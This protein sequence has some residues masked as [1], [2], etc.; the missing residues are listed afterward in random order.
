MKNQEPSQ[1]RAQLY[2]LKVTLNGITPPIWRTLVCPVDASLE[3]LSVLIQEAFGWDG[4]HLYKFKIGKTD[5]D[6]DPEMFEEKNSQINTEVP[7]LAEVTLISL[8]LKKGD[9]FEY[10][11]DFGDDWRHTIAVE[12]QRD[13]RVLEPEFGCRAGERAAPFEDCGGIVGYQE[14]LAAKQDKKHPKRQAHNVMYDLDSFDPNQFDVASVNERIQI[15]LM[16]DDEMRDLVYRMSDEDSAD[17]IAENDDSSA[18][19]D[20][21]A[22]I[23]LLLSVAFT[24]QMMANDPKEV[25]L[26]IEQLTKIGVLEED[27][28]ARVF[29][30]FSEEFFESHIA[31]RAFDLKLYLKNLSLLSAEVEAER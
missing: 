8:N 30:V 5:Y 9:Q 16:L 1:V 23:D 25:L 21:E 22:R 26:T 18:D 12:E 13:A 24:N 10:L 15:E 27:A 2:S 28:F 4:S 7:L 31:E 20:K 3:L 14:I 19:I 11:Y 29:E 17:V 6:C